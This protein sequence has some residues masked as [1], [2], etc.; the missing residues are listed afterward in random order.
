MGVIEKHRE[1]PIAGDTLTEIEREPS[2]PGPCGAGYLP[3]DPTRRCSK[4]AGH[5]GEHRSGA[6]TWRDP[7]RVVAGDTPAA[8][9]EGNRLAAELLRQ[10]RED[11]RIIGWTAQGACGT[12][13]RPI[14]GRDL[15]PDMPQAGEA[16]R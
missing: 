16:D 12:N 2:G 13:P 14:R 11:D 3:D 8:A 9:D 1:H 15:R 5:D 6:V 4:G 7:L 10:D